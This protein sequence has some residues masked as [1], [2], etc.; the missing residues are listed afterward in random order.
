MRQTILAADLDNTLL[1][2]YKHRRKDDICVEWIHDEPQGY[3]PPEVWV[4]LQKAAKQIMIVPI[5]TRSIHQYQRIH[6]PEGCELRPVSERL[7]R[8]IER[9]GPPGR[10]QGS[11]CLAGCSYRQGTQKGG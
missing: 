5:T 2:S 11:V 3:M 1:Y 4:G 10:I 6:W 7:P 8:D 9:T